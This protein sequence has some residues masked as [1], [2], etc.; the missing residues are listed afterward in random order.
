[1]AKENTAQRAEL[2]RVGGAVRGRRAASFLIRGVST[3]YH[4]NRNEVFREQTRTWCAG[5]RFSVT[6]IKL[7]VYYGRAVRERSK[8]KKKMHRSAEEA[9][10]DQDDGRCTPRR[11]ADA[12]PSPA[13]SAAKLR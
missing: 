13:T 7:D 3:T 5:V 6:V 1:M 8:E 10:A 4:A 9:E 11:S 2:A 12:L